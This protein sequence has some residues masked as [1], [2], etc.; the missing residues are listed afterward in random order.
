M[1]VKN[2]EISHKQRLQQRC[3]EQRREFLTLKSRLPEVAI[4]LKSDVA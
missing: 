4:K 3:E 2:E 1:R